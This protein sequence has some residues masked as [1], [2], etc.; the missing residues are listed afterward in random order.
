[1]VD[2]AY[3]LRRPGPNAQIDVAYTGAVAPEAIKAVGLMSED[4]RDIGILAITS[5]DRLH[6][7]WTGAQR[8]REQ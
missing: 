2:G 5:A 8:Q 7:G 4:R 1:I 3:W 6:A